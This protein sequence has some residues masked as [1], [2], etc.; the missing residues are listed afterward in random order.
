MSPAESSISI[1]VLRSLVRLD[2]ET[3]RLYWLPRNM[4]HFAHCGVNASRA[5]NTW[6]ARFAGKECFNTPHGAGYF[7]GSIFNEKICAHRVVFA[8]A[9]GRW[10]TLTVDHINHNRKDNRPLNL[11][12]VSHQEN[13]RNAPLSKANTTGVTGVHFDRSSGKFD[14]YINIDGVKRS[15]GAFQTLE[16]A[17]AAR[18]AAEEKHGFHQNHG[19]KQS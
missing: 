9:N 13:A 18:R 2:V 4:A 16:C 15:V 6:N 19:R 8:L 17:A 5:L 7:H 11:R 12:D 10:P 1:D 3:G 14:A